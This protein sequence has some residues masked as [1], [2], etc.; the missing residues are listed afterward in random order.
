M[1]SVRSRKYQT[2]GAVSLGLLCF[3]YRQLP[4][5]HLRP[6]VPW[7]LLQYDLVPGWPFY[8]DDAI[9]IAER[10]NLVKDPYINA[11]RNWVI[12]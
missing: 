2:V 8:N 1:A 9:A 4:P 5:S 10:H 7:L 11:G 12:D 3:T 6:C